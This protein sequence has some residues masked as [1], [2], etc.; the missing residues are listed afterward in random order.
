MSMN[1]LMQDYWPT[2]A[3]YQAM[4]GQV[5]AALTDADLAYTPGGANPPLGA[6]CQAIGETEH[7]YIESF[8]TF[9]TDFSYRHPA[10]GPAG[11]LAQLRA[12]YAAL[13]EQL[14]AVLAG[15]SEDQVQHQRVQRG[16]GHAPPVT[17]QLQ[18][19]QEALLIFYGKASV[20]LKALNKPLAEQF[21][22]WIA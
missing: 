12:W 4:R 5:L 17:I 9:T 14:E 3:L 22:A 6:L 8:R 18:I 13:D 19:Y 21:R 7:A 2:F 11:S 15:L 20:Y 10:S 16:P 1:S